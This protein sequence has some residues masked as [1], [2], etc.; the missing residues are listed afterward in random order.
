MPSSNHG[1]LMWDMRM[2]RS[3]KVKGWRGSILSETYRRIWRAW[4]LVVIS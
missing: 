3:Q 2:V 4:D 1:E